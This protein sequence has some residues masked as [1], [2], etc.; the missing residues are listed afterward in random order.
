MEE[1]RA[2]MIT[3]RIWEGPDGGPHPIRTEY[4]V[5]A[6][7]LTLMGGPGDSL[8]EA[9]MWVL[10]RAATLISGLNWDHPWVTDIESVTFRIYK[11]GNVIWSSSIDELRKKMLAIF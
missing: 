1:V 8:V 6:P 2:D 5:E 9:K 10:G 7:A 11:N 3:V 4:V